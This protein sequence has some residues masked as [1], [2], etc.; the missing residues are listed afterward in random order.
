MALFDKDHLLNNP[1][2][3]TAG[4]DYTPVPL[5]T[6]GVDHKQ[7]ASEH[8]TQISLG[9]HW[10]FGED[11]RWQLDPA[12][13][14][15]M[16]T[17]AGS[18]LALVDRNNEIVLQYRKNAQAGVAK[19]TMTSIVDYSPADGVTRN[20]LQ[21]LATNRDGQPVA[22]APVSWSVPSDGSVTLLTSTTVTDANGYASLSLT[23]T[24]AQT[25]Q[26]TAQS[27]NVSALLE[28][29]FIAQ[30]A[31]QIA[32][33]VGQN[34]ATADGSSVNTLIATLTDNNGL[35]VAG[36]KV[37]WTLPEGITLLNSSEMSDANG[38][39]TLSFSSLVAGNFTIKAVAG[40]LTASAT[41]TFSANSAS[42][43]IDALTITT[44]GSLANGQSLNIAQ[45]IVT[46]ASG[47]A[48]S[49]QTVTWSSS[50]GTVK[51]GE[52]LPTDAS[53]K[54]TVSFSDSLAE[55]V[56]L[57]ATLVNG[58]S[59]STQGMF[60]T[61]QSSIVLRDLSVTSGAAAS[62]SDVNTAT[63]SVTDANGAA[64]ADV[65]VT[66]SVSGSAKLSSSTVK[67]NSEGNAV[68]TLTDSVAETVNVEAKL[69]NGSS[70]IKES[71]FTADLQSAQL[72][73]SVGSD[74]LA[75]GLAT[76]EVAVALKDKNGLP[77]AGEAVTLAASGSGKLST[78]SATTD[79]AG[80]ISA[81]LTD[82]VAEAVTVTV[83]LSNGKQTVAE[84][85]FID[86]GVTSLET[87][88]AS[89]K[90][91]GTDSATLTVVVVD[92][93]GQVVANTPVSFSVSGGALLS[94]TTVMTNS[95]GQA[96][97][98]LTH[99]TGETVTVTAKTMNSQ[100]DSGKT[101][102]VQFIASTITGLTVNGTSND[103]TRTFSADSGFPQ[104]GF[105]GASFSFLID[106]GDVPVTDY[107][108]SSNQNWVSVNDG[109]VTFV[110]TPSSSGQEVVITATPKTGKGTLTWTFKLAYWF[111]F[112]N[113]V[114]GTAAADSYCSSLGQWVPPKDLLDYTDQGTTRVGSLWSEWANSIPQSNGYDVV[115]AAETGSSSRYYMFLADGH[116]YANAAI[117]EAHGQKGN[118]NFGAACVT[119]LN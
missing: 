35:A 48:L 97:V 85:T 91:N 66:F 64:M 81:T 70:V 69:T 45:V 80:E 76:S 53:G 75:D 100:T 107:N 5:L 68:V 117:A 92:A 77:L 52:S 29:H 33:T 73:L 94:A 56:E 67:T 109:T 39:I 71:S 104:T 12:N 84:A 14:H 79:S 46:D 23:S 96:Q 74:A 83:T 11:W 114:V 8:D 22:H 9:L 21:V 86:F 112:G 87:S 78:L 93:K 1:Q 18:R 106:N 4:V 90:A 34:N 82:S 2:A 38:Q 19:M 105:T 99:D 55:T 119:N 20:V 16:R 13:V 72:T 43:K 25:V 89:V 6:L 32:L 101:A 41:V 61:D 28:S 51:L 65:T 98:T 113:A 108:W 27:N 102:E 54:T 44:D 37:S 116:V 63:V 30:T 59:A 60:I 36:Q 47:N 24:Q 88:T 42:A 3:I 40:S 15:S 10:R 57:T 49:G 7:G 111:T 17:L 58:N 26:I 103:L 110:S 118:H 50:S 115:W 95:N 31:S 62:G